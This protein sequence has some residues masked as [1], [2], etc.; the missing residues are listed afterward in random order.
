MLGKNHSSI[1][2]V[3][4]LYQFGLNSAQMNPVVLQLGLGFDVQC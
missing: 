1:S 4:M 3:D 2:D